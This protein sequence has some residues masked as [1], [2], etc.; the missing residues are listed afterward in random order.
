MGNVP[1][2]PVTFRM[3]PTRKPTGNRNIIAIEKLAKLIITPNN[4][5]QKHR[6]T[7]HM[8]TRFVIG[9]SR[10]IWRKNKAFNG[11]VNT[12]D[13]RDTPKD[14]CTPFHSLAP[15]ECLPHLAGCFDKPSVILG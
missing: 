4:P 6:E 11:V 14:A 10:L 8:T 15:M 2:H 9:A 3:Y 5:K 12:A 7:A 1:I 13:A